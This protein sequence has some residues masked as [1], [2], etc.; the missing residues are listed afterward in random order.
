MVSHQ[1]FLLGLRDRRRNLEYLACP[2]ILGRN[3][4]CQGV[5]NTAPANLR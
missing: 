4:E 2:D 1:R 5:Q 3:L